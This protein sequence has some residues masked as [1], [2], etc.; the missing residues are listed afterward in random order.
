MN[1]KN[2]ILG[3]CYISIA[4]SKQLESVEIYEEIKMSIMFGYSPEQFKLLCNFFANKEAK[5]K[6]EFKFKQLVYNTWLK[7]ENRLN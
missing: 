3:Y 1:T 7:L 6:L 2:E 5:T 4:Y